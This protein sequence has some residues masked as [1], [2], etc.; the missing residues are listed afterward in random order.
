MLIYYRTPSIK[1]L[2][3]LTQGNVTLARTVKR[4]LLAKRAE[5]EAAIPGHDAVRYGHDTP[6]LRLEAVGEVLGMHGV[7]EFRTKRGVRVLYCNAGDTYAATVLRVGR[8]YRVGTWGD[9]AETYGTR[10]AW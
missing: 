7:E 10:D 3:E 1:A 8:H 9:V 6:T 4:L 2:R 5:L